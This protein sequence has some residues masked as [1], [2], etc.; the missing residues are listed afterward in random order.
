[1]VVLGRPHSWPAMAASALDM[2]T[3]ATVAASPASAVTIIPS[4]HQRSR[5]SSGERSSRPATGVCISV[6]A[7]TLPPAEH[8]RDVKKPD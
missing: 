7:M 2:T 8:G 1:M 6:A 5:S 4:R 3:R